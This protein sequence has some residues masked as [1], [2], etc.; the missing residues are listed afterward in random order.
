MRSILRCI[1]TVFTATFSRKSDLRRPRGGQEVGFKKAIACVRYLTN[2]GIIARHASDTESTINYMRDYLRWFHETKGLFL[3]FRAGKV[4]KA[5]AE[6]VQRELNLQRESRQSA[7]D[8]LSA[9]LLAQLQDED[10]LERQYLINDILE[11]ESDFNFPKIH[12]LSHNAD[13]ISRYSSLPQYS[14]E[15]CETS[16]KLFKNAYR[17][18]NHV[19][20]IPQII[21]GYMWEH[22]FAIREL[23]MKAWA[24][25]EPA[26]MRRLQD[27]IS[28]KRRLP[29]FSKV[30]GDTVYMQLRG[31][32]SEV[33]KIEHVVEEFHIAF[34]NKHTREFLLK[35]VCGD[36]SDPESDSNNL[37]N[38]CMVEAFIKR[39]PAWTFL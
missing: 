37:I 3:C 29:F 2:F 1:L 36:A 32:R 39:R 11:V 16:Y 28:R 6:A 7:L 21:Q 17:E 22:S 20:A 12:L 25:L 30:P 15:S 31:K 19:D 34:L 26:I 18:S 23:N 35:N 13:R 10:Q 33:T 4:A 24:D 9:K 27:V 5:K 38:N 8:N 14:T